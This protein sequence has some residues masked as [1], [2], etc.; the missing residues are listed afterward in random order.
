M[1]NH[2]EFADF[3]RSQAGCHE[4]VM[5]SSFKRSLPAM[6]RGQIL[7][8]PRGE[9]TRVID[10]PTELKEHTNQPAP[11]DGRVVQGVFKI[12]DQRSQTACRTF[13]LRARHLL[14]AHEMCGFGLQICPCAKSGYAHRNSS[15]SF[16]DA[17]DGLRTWPP[18]RTGVLFTV[19][20]ALSAGFT[21]FAV[22]TDFHVANLQLLRSFIGRVFD[23]FNKV[24]HFAGRRLQTR[25]A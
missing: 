12:E 17:I 18:Q 1:A 20:Q 3:A 21:D 22:F 2:L 19:T 10:M 14:V 24:R 9:E 16:K 8:I 15:Y 23:R 6:H 11:P 25:T 4:K 5:K 7:A 13:G